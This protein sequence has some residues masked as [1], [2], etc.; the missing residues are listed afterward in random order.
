MQYT[1]KQ[2]EFDILK[3]QIEQLF[4]EVVSIWK[5]SDTK[6]VQA[7]KRLAARTGGILS[8]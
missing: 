2:S 1:Y 4:N 5:D 3:I 8:N 6:K 7:V